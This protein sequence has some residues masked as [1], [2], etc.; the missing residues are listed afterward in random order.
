[1]EVRQVLSHIGN[2]SVRTHPFGDDL[3]SIF[4]TVLP[5]GLTLHPD[6]TGT[7]LMSIYEILPDESKERVKRVVPSPD[8]NDA[9]TERTTR[10]LLTIAMIMAVLSSL[11]A[12][13]LVAFISMSKFDSKER[14]PAADII[15]DVIV[16]FKQDDNNN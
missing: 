11:L 1:M 13:G 14:T 16:I 15:E 2:N 9:N 3:L 7:D 10:S 12:I 6:C 4:S 5:T 8:V